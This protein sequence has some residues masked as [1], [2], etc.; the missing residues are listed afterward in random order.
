MAVILKWSFKNPPPVIAGEGV[1]P[2]R[3]NPVGNDSTPTNR[4][5]LAATLEMEYFL[6]LTVIFEKII[7]LDQR[8]EIFL[9]Y[10]RCQNFS[11]LLSPSPDKRN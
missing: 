10:C 5:D 8:G 11:T 6:I 7:H 2:D 3:G 9:V 4:E 1:W